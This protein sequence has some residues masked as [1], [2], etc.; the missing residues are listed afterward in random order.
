LKNIELIIKL[1]SRWIQFFYT[2][3]NMPLRIVNQSELPLGNTPTSALSPIH[4]KANLQNEYGHAVGCVYFFEDINIWKTRIEI[5]LWNQTPGLHG[6]HIHEFGDNDYLGEYPN[7]TMHT[8]QHCGMFGGHYN[9]YNASHGAP[10]DDFSARHVGDMGNVKV[11]PDGNGHKVFY[12]RL[13]RLRGRF[14][15]IGR[16][17]VLHACADDLGHG[18]DH[19]SRITGNSGKRLSC[20]IIRQMPAKSKEVVWGC[21][22]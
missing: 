4:A 18:G 2:Q 6:I 7:E 17:V 20:G 8:S 5:Q 15:V 9:P 22:A 10:T 3:I 16:T 14:N 12:D 13:I 19:E 11:N 21:K 1:N